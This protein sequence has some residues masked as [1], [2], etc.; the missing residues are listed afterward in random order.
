MKAA[1]EQLQFE[2]AIALRD[3]IRSLRK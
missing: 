3:K 1:A 2:R